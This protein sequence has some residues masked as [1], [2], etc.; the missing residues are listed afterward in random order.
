MFLQI[1]NTDG[2]DASAKYNS[3]AD[4]TATTEGLG[5]ETANAAKDGLVG[6]LPT[7]TIASYTGAN[8]DSS[9]KTLTCSLTV[10]FT[11]GKLFGS[12]N[13]R[14]YYKD[15]TAAVSGA[16]AQRRLTA[17]NDALSGCK[18]VLTIASK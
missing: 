3:I 11:W 16:E 10:T 12:N 9:K 18:Y 7:F 17:L 5:G 15:S 4:T 13:P 6:K 1:T 14:T 8:Y 2:S